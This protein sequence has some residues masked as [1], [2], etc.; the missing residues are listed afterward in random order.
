MLFGVLGLVLA[1]RLV[2]PNLDDATRRFAFEPPPDPLEVSFH[3]PPGRPA[4]GVFYRRSTGVVTFLAG[5]VDGS[6]L[7]AS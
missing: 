7:V 6:P 5:S 1:D 2:A 4:I 3:P